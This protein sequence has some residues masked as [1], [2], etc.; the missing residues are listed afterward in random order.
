[1][2]IPDLNEHGLLPVGIHDCMFSELEVRF[3]QNQWVTDT[4]SHSPREVL[5]QQRGKLCA[6]LKGYL[7][8]LRRVGLDV[9]VLVDGSFVTE[10]P[11]PNDIDLIV[12]FP[13]DHDFSRSLPLREYNLLSKR[14]LRESGYL[15][16][17]FVVARGDTGFQTAVR[18]FQMVRNREDLTKGLLRVKP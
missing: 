14:R 9:E 16:D 18:L 5:C 8:E 17:L 6:S 10:K 7:A 2:A 1:M 3:G 11:D 12:V 13:A 4:Q 15:F